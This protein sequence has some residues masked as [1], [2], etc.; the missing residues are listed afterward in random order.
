MVISVDTSRDRIGLSLKA[1]HSISQQPRAAPEH[2]SA[3]KA[4]NC[5]LDFPREGKRAREQERDGG[6]SQ[7]QKRTARKRMDDRE[8][9]V[10]GSKAANTGRASDPITLD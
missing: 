6:L 8:R 2:M 9:R 4:P 7:Q 10:L 1:A 5:K 3:E